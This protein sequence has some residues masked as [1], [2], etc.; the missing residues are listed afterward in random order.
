M[1]SKL[2]VREI[3][4]I[5]DIRSKKLIKVLIHMSIIIQKV[6]VIIKVKIL[7]KLVS[8]KTMNNHFSCS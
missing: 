2:K 6:N 5:I 1:D 4:S 3:V 8:K 7:V